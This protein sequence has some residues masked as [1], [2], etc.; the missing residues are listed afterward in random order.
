MVLTM[1]HFNRAKKLHQQLLTTPATIFSNLIADIQHARESIDAEFYIVEPDRTGQL[2]CDILR[3]KARQGLSVRLLVDG[4]GSRGL[5]RTLREG[6]EGA[7][8]DIRTTGIIG[9]SR[10]HRKMTIVDNRIAHIGGI[11]IADRYAVGNRLGIWHDLQLR[12]SG[13]AVASLRALFD[14]DYLTAAGIRTVAPSPDSNISPSL[15]WSEC[16]AG[17]A[18]QQLLHDTIERAQHSLTIT[19]PYFFP[20]R[21]TLDLFAS[22]VRRGVS[23]RVIL[24]ERCDIWAIDHLARHYLRQ[25]A[26]LGIELLVLRNAFVHAKLALVDDRIAILGSAN[27]DARSLRINREIMASTTSCEVCRKASLFIKRLTA[28][29]S[30]PTEAEL[31][32]IIPSGVARLF[33]A[34]L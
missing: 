33:E 30:P 3:R 26:S 16:D 7:G 34:V 27:L 15:H 29:C 9:H 18:M 10:N 8:V 32:S 5:P 19:T 13:E 2:L 6:M 11:N 24:P 31:H 14:Y 23:V 4:F 12:F 28:R 22:A 25:A 17:E 20:P 1:F 21:T